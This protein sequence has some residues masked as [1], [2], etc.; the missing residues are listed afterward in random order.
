MQTD[1]EYSGLIEAFKRLNIL[2]FDQSI[3]LGKAKMMYKIHNNIAPSY[4][5]GMFLMHDATLNNTSLI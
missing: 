4:L 1:I 2:L 3:F 5:N